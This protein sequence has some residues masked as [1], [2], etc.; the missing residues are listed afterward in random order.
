MQQSRTIVVEQNENELLYRI[1]GVSA[2]VPNL[3]P[4]GVIAYGAAMALISEFV[5]Y[6]FIY[7]TS[8]FQAL[9]S[10][11][12]KHAQ[13]LETAKDSNA[14]KGV[15][16]HEARLQG[17]ETAA[18]KQIASVQFKAGIIVSASRQFVFRHII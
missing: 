17:W 16:K 18:S 8:S 4:L 3:A 15:K 6:W 10:N 7:R 13:K 9:K 11:I 14:S 1:I 12:E 5:A 2:M